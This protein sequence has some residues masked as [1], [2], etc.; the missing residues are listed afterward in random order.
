MKTIPMSSAL[1]GC[2]LWHS[3]SSTDIQN[4]EKLWKLCAKKSQHLPSR[5]R[6]YMVLSLLGFSLSLL[7]QRKI[8]KFPEQILG[9]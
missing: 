2:E 8:D 3:M 7:G 4:V 9:K 1:Y 6:T 5:T